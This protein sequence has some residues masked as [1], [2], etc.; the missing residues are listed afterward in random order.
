MSISS[1]SDIRQTAIFT[2]RDV[3]DPLG[4]WGGRNAITGDVS[5]GSV[6]TIFRVPA[7]LRPAYVYTCYSVQI[8]QDDGT[9]DRNPMRVRLLTNW[10]NIDP[11]AGVQA[12]S[13]HN[14]V[15]ADGSASLFEPVAGPEGVLLAPNDRFILLF[16]P[17]PSVISMPILE[18]E[19]ESNQDGET[20][21][22][23]CYG[24]FWDRTV[25]DTPGGLRHP[26]SD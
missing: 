1:N 22:F 6:R 25:M 7:D 16:D 11:Q 24:Y 13:T 20:Y 8:S 10:P 12:Y 9:L 5:T 26:G 18:L 4:V 15:T 21:I 19:Y 14:I 3:R 2:P 23:E 17:R